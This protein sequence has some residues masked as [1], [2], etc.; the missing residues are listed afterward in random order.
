MTISAYRQEKRNESDFEWFVRERKVCDF[1]HSEKAM[2]SAFRTKRE[3]KTKV[4]CEN[5]KNL[6]VLI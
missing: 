3:K 5:I 4:G 2:K 6:L 1:E